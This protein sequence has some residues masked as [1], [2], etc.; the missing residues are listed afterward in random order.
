MLRSEASLIEQ[1]LDVYFAE[2]DDVMLRDRQMTRA[3]RRI[4]KTAG[5]SPGRAR[6]LLGRVIEAHWHRS[7]ILGRHGCGG[8]DLL[9]ALRCHALAGAPDLGTISANLQDRWDAALKVAASGWDVDEV[10]HTFAFL[11]AIPHLESPL[12]SRA[13]VRFLKKEIRRN[14]SSPVTVSALRVA[15]AC[16]LTGHAV[17]AGEPGAWQSAAESHHDAVLRAPAGSFAQWTAVSAQLEHVVTHRRHLTG[18]ESQAPQE[19][20]SPPEA[21]DHPL[22]LMAMARSARHASDAGDRGRAGAAAQTAATLA[23]RAAGLLR[24]WPLTIRTDLLLECGEIALAASDEPGTNPDPGI[25]ALAAECLATGG[26]RA[27]HDARAWHLTA[28]VLDR[29]AERATPAERERLRAAS[30]GAWEHAVRSVPYNAP[31]LGLDIVRDL[32]GN[33]H[34]N[35]LAGVLNVGGDQDERSA[36]QGYL[37]EAVDPGL[38]QATKQRLLRRWPNLASEAAA[39]ALAAR[40]A[41]RAL[42]LLESCRGVLWGQLADTRW[43][44]AALRQ[45]NPYFALKLEQLAAS[46]RG[47]QFAAAPAASWG[48]RERSRTARSF[49]SLLAELRSFEGQYSQILWTPDPATVQGLLDPHET[50]AVVSAAR[51]GCFAVLISRDGVRQ[52]ELDL[53]RVDGAQDLQ[54]R[55]RDIVGRLATSRSELDRRSGELQMRKLLTHLW[56]AIA[57]PVLSTLPRVPGVPDDERRV[58]W[59]PTGPLTG[60]PLHAAGQFRGNSP[61]RELTVVGRVVSSYTPTLRA[62][63]RAKRHAPGAP[64]GSALVVAMPRTPGLPD[65]PGAS[66]EAEAVRE[67]FPGRVRR[68]TGRR[69]TEARVIR[70]LPRYQ[71]IHFSCHGSSRPSQL[72][73]HRS[74]LDIGE[75]G[76]LIALAESGV[77]FVFLSACSTAEGDPSLPD[78]FLHITAALHEA[79]PAVVGT[80]WPV[81]DAA[82]TPDLVASFYSAA[83]ASGAFDPSGTAA[84]LHRTLRTLLFDPAQFREHG[85]TRSPWHYFPTMWAPFIHVGR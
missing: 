32:L 24:S 40:E 64:A 13:A 61:D 83:S 38:P 3:L 56:V 6:P 50:V 43:D 7:L 85:E 9:A 68:L 31:V 51:A 81:D 17:L 46:V 22:V 30:A 2:G 39:V 5:R 77:Q 19:P 84:A 62:F 12:A 78:E 8:S 47:A 33:R 27:E 42:D 16:V 74:S 75:T 72:H 80:L 1:A 14:R 67:R 49:V 41:T 57:E 23:S 54:R 26:T 73:L 11:P 69:A 44:V 29:Q 63:I 20:S 79:V 53:L 35:V 76:T 25:L 21:P 60:L 37:Q 52:I 36:L 4:G 66:A 71:A 65:L 82:L 59:C 28:L 18:Q 15:T 45:K 34:D 48:D 70:Q 10:L 55:L 58:W